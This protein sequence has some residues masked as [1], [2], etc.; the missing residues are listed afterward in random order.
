MFRLHWGSYMSETQK[1]K[2]MPRH[3]KVIQGGLALELALG[4]CGLLFVYMVQAGTKVSFN[5]S[6]FFPHLLL[7]HYPPLR[8]VVA[9]GLSLI[10]LALLVFALSRRVKLVTIGAVC[11]FVLGGALLGFT[12]SA[13]KERQVT[14]YNMVLAHGRSYRLV[15]VY[16]Q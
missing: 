15:S 6:V 9:G 11:L 16:R 14:P 4:I 1:A 3:R 10:L 7:A 12:I 8:A 2:R 5:R 13:F